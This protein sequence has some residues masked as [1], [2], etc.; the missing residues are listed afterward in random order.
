M[1]TKMLHI[2]SATLK[3]TV[4]Q[5]ERIR[6]QTGVIPFFIDDDGEIY[7]MLIGS[8]HAGNWSIPKGKKEKHLSKKD[9]AA[10]EA[11]E[12]AG[13]RGDILGKLGEYQYRKGSTGVMQNVI[14][15][16]MQVERQLKKFPEQ[17]M[18]VRKWFTVDKAAK[19]IGK[20]LSHIVLA[21]KDYAPE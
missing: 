7:V 13:I 11:Y 3:E 8:R 17:G 15:Y 20:K 14:V 4:D 19:K 18:R 16:A 21:V 1:K 10:I 12:E 9:S 5:N 2:E 6:K